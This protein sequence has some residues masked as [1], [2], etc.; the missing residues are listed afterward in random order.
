MTEKKDVSMS[1]KQRRK[2]RTY[3]EAINPPTLVKEQVNIDKKEAKIPLEKENESH[4]EDKEMAKEAEAHTENEIKENNTQVASNQN[5]ITKA[6]EES[7]NIPQNTITHSEEKS[8]NPSISNEIQEKDPLMEKVIDKTLSQLSKITS[9]EEL[10][11][12]LLALLT[13]PAPKEYELNDRKEVLQRFI[14][15]NKVLHSLVVSEYNKLLSIQKEVSSKEEKIN[16]FT[17]SLINLHD[18]LSDEKIKNL[19]YE[20]RLK[21]Y[22]Q[23]ECQ[24]AFPKEG[25]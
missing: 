25:F 5:E 24:L 3:Y 6:E 21:P 10:K 1:T 23:Q 19:Q 17:S 9:K 22:L 13:S 2:K 12:Y 14:S 15:K 20:E 16:D 8:S 7:T 4:H 18:V 11:K